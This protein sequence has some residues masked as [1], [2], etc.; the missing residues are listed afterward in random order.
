MN[1]TAWQGPF[2][3]VVIPQQKYLQLAIMKAEYYT[4]NGE[5]AKEILLSLLDKID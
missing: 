2:M 1:K 4:I 5:I 3:A